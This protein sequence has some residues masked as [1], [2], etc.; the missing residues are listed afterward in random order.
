VSAHRICPPTGWHLVAARNGPTGSGCAHLDVSDARLRRGRVASS[1]RA[2]EFKS[3]IRL[4]DT[5]RLAWHPTPGP[6]GVGIPRRPRPRPFRPYPLRGPRE[7]SRLLRSDDLCDLQTSLR[8][9]RRTAALSVAWSARRNRRWRDR[10]GGAPV[11]GRASS[12]ATRG[13]PAAPRGCV[14]S[15]ST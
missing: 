14:A 6:V 4:E 7:R 8:R 5:P 1:R 11:L 10:G 13:P 3:T 15:R 9:G 2:V 12:R